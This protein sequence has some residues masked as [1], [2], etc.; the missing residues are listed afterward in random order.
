MAYGLGCRL[1]VLGFRLQALV[2]ESDLR[3]P[4]SSFWA[5]DLRP[6]VMKIVRGSRCRL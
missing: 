1:S 6:E 2:F 5:E 3:V 4:G